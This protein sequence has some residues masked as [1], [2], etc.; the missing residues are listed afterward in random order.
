MPQLKNIKRTARKEHRCDLCYQP[1]R[2]GT[3]YTYRSGF[4]DGQAW[5]A[6]E[7]LECH[8]VMQAWGKKYGYPDDGE[9]P[10]DIYEAIDDL[11]MDINQV[12]AHFAHN[13]DVLG[14]IAVRKYGRNVA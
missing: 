8:D 11:E 5:D 4:Y 14:E 2:P 7:H 10:A 3:V 12:A 6:K 9:G 1:I 13:H